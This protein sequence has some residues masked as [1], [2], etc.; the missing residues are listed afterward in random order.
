MEN[1]SGCSYSMKWPVVLR[2]CGAALLWCCAPPVLR[3]FATYRRHP[4]LIFQKLEQRGGELLGV[5][6]LDEVAGAAAP[7]HYADV[8]DLG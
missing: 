1:S 7:E 2:S 3:S 4:Q 5:F 6:E 8:G